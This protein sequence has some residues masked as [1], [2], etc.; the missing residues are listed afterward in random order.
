MRNKIGKN[1]QHAWNFAV[2]YPGWHTYSYCDRASRRAI[3]WLEARGLVEVCRHEN[4]GQFRARLTVTGRISEA[5]RLLPMY[6][7]M[8]V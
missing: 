7:A 4:D 5:I 2:T 8:E 3:E 1:I 6:E